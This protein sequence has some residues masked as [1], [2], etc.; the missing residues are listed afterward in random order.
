MQRSPKPLHQDGSP[1][2]VK[3]T[4]ATRVY[5]SPQ[6]TD[7]KKD[8]FMRMILAK[9]NSNVAYKITRTKT[10]SYQDAPAP[11]T[12]LTRELSKK[13]NRPTA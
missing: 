4:D 11:S 1:P 3:A 8:N 9:Q 12:I 10:P 6:K 7:K 13:S 2:G 5:L